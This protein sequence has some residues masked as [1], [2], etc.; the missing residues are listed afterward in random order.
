VPVDVPSLVEALRLAHRQRPQQDGVDE[1][2][3]GDVGA[4]AERQRQ[5]RRE[6]EAWR[7]P[8]HAQRVADVSTQ[9]VH[10]RTPVRSV[11]PTRR[12]FLFP[13]S[14]CIKLVRV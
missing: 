8:H 13:R 6:R 10:A 7:S 11:H 4:D 1:R 12:V 2:E 14:S 9:H 3:D 5:G